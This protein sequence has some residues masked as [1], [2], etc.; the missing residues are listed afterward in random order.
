MGLLF[1]QNKAICNAKD[2][3]CLYNI[4]L[5]KS[6]RQSA[7]LKDITNYIKDRKSRQIS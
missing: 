1:Q 6:T 3:L 5:N 4:D 7:V 2:Y